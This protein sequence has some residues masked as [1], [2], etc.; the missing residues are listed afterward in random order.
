MPR[1]H[2]AKSK[3]GARPAIEQ[4]VHGSAPPPEDDFVRQFI[5]SNPSP[6]PWRPHTEAALRESLT[7]AGFKVTRS[8]CLETQPV[9]ALRLRG[10]L[11]MTERDLR[12]CIRRVVRELG[13]RAPAGGMAVGG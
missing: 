3:L 13:C 5:M 6:P 10:P 7:G 11:E 8:E 2:R 1:R 9:V 4:P 12:R